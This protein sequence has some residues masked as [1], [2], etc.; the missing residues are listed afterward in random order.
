MSGKIKVQQTSVSSTPLVATT[1]TA[2]T[3]TYTD[4]IRNDYSDGYASVLIVQTG[5][6]AD[7]DLSIQASIDNSTYYDPYDASGSALGNIVTALGV[8]AATRYQSITLPIAPWIR[9]K[10]D[11]DG[12]GV[13]SL[14]LITKET[15]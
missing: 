4:G 1:I 3:T 5:A 13:Y 14:Y 10:V 15:V 6:A 8:G 11:P 2:G 9:F 12:T 7:L